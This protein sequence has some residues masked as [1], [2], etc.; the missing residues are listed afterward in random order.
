[1]L[2]LLAEAKKEGIRG[3]EYC[4]VDFHAITKETDFSPIDKH[5][6]ELTKNVGFSKF[7]MEKEEIVTHLKQNSIIRTNCMDCLDRTNAA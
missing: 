5:I 3:L 1:M 4:H 7:S 6:Y 2:D